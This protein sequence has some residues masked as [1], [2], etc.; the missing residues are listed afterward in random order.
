MVRFVTANTQDYERFLAGETEGIRSRDT[1]EWRYRLTE[2]LIRAVSPTVIALQE[3]PGHSQERANAAIAQLAEATGMN[4]MVRKS[5]GPGD[6]GQY[7]VTPG[8]TANLGFGL[9]WADG[10]EPLQDSWLAVRK[11]FWHAV[12]AVTLDVG[13]KHP[14]QYAVGHAPPTAGAERRAAEAALTTKVLLRPD[15]SP[16]TMFGIDQNSMGEDRVYDKMPHL[17]HFTDEEIASRFV[18]DRSSAAAFT[19]GGL[20]DAVHWLEVGRY[21]AAGQTHDEAGVLLTD[22]RAI[23][24]TGHYID[25]QYG[26]ANYGARRIDVIRVSESMLP[27]LIDYEVFDDVLGAAEA[28]DHIWTAVTHDPRLL[29]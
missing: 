11:G 28:S 8:N 3:L 1:E 23:P 26:M 7:A 21:V 29:V 24:T 9:M 25:P 19:R 17:P 18:N 13:G 14:I 5:R 4:C 22:K 6:P 15:G 27:A 10:V 12:G 16:F 20:I 2:R